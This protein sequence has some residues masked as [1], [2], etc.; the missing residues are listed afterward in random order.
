[1][2]ILLINPA[3]NRYGGI[4]GHGG[5][6]MPLN[7]CYIAAYARKNHPQSEFKIL[8][9]E[10]LGIGH[11]ETVEETA[12]Y[13][14]DLIGIT[15]NTCVFDSVIT[16]TSL[17]K[18]RLP[19]VPI[20]IGGPHPSALPERTLTESA[21]DF[22]AIGEGEVSFEKLISHLKEGKSSWEEIEGL[23]YRELCGRIR[24]NKPRKLIED[25]DMLPFPARDLINNE[26]Y[27]PPPTKRVSLGRN[28]LIAASRGCPHNCGFCGA[29]LVWG[30]K[31][32]TRK[33]EFI[34]AELEQCVNKYDISSFNFTD[35]LFT[36]SKKHILEICHLIKQK[37][38]DIAWVCSARAQHLD[39]ET[40][41]AMK[42][43]GCR[44][45]SFGIESGSP[46]ILKR[47]NKKLDLK[48]ALRTVW[49]TKETG[50]TTHASFILGY[51]GETEETI[52]ETIRF[53]KKL[54]T[55]IAAFFIASPLPGTRLYKEAKEKGYLRKDAKWIDY[56]PLSNMEP[57]LQL[58]HLP[59]GRVKYW[60]RRALRIY[61]FRPKYIISR[62]LAIRHWYELANLLGGLKIFFRIKK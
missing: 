3:F 10:I 39:E 55:Q 30:R 31:I 5:S 1:V 2:R 26:L 41:S 8:D 56:S 53:A 13:S 40:L 19:E 38:L 29:K 43:A 46:K 49:R 35:E 33:P 47:I 54:N 6:M 17:L 51:I 23:G 50:I 62:F 12:R 21:A 4:K 22:V 58:P 32:R 48:E 28:T 24:I 42:E 16:L 57:V 60:H 25:L 61:Y 7:L 27:M 9:S 45:I 37:G 11:E 36:N 14:P 52:K 20:I 15:S 44:E 59:A 18:Q 34:V